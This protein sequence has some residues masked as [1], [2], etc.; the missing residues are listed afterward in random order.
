VTEPVTRPYTP[1]KSP[2]PLL[3]YIIFAILVLIA[4]A[5]VWLS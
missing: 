1:K 4:T 2:R 3:V 5:I